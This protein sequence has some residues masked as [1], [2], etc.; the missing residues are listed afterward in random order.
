VEE[1]TLTRLT[2]YENDLIRNKAINILRNLSDKNKL[3]GDELAL[4]GAFLILERAENT[5]LAKY[6]GTKLEPEDVPTVKNLAIQ[7]LKETIKKNEVS[8]KIGETEGIDVTPIKE[9]NEDLDKLLLKLV[10]DV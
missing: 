3:S 1:Q 8:M 10:A 4:I 5:K 9:A 7:Y 2:K 6:E